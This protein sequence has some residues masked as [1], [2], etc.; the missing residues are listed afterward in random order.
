MTFALLMA[1]ALA[2][3]TAVTTSSAKRAKVSVSAPTCLLSPHFAGDALYTGSV[4][5]QD[6]PLLT[7]THCKI[8]GAHAVHIAPENDTGA[9]FPAVLQ[10]ESPSGSG[11]AVA[12]KG[13][14]GGERY[15]LTISR[16]I[17]ADQ[18]ARAG[19][20]WRI[21]DITTDKQ[22]ASLTITTQHVAPELTAVQVRYKTDAI[23]SAIEPRIV[24]FLNNAM[25]RARE[26]DPDASYKDA[27]VVPAQENSI[28]IRNIAEFSGMRDFP[29]HSRTVADEAEVW[30][31]NPKQI[32]GLEVENADSEKSKCVVKDHENCIED[33]SAIGF[34]MKRESEQP[35]FVD[36]YYSRSRTD[37]GAVIVRRMRIQVQLAA[38]ARRSS[39]PFPL[40]SH[41]YVQCSTNR[42]PWRPTFDIAENGQTLAVNDYV[43]NRDDCSI[44][45]PTHRIDAQI[46]QDL[47]LGV[48]E[49]STC[50]W[51]SVPKYRKA[52]YVVD[53]EPRLREQ[54]EKEHGSGDGTRVNKSPAD[55]FKRDCIE[56]SI[57]PY[58]SLVR[59]APDKTKNEDP[60]SVPATAMK[61]AP[62][63]ETATATKKAPE[64]ET[65]TDKDKHLDRVRALLGPQ[66]LVYEIV[67]ENERPVWHEVALDL[68]AADV[69]IPLEFGKKNTHEAEEFEVRFETLAQAKTD[70]TS[71]PRAG[72]GQRG[73]LCRNPTRCFLARVR[74]KGRFGVAHV[75]GTRGSNSVRVFATIPLDFVAFRF[76]PS[77]R[78]ATSSADSNIAQITT[79]NTGLLLAIEPWNYITNR[80]MFALPFRFLFGGM[81]HRWQ[82]GKFE[83]S[84]FTGGALALPLF[85]GLDANDR[86]SFDLTLSAG[87]ELSLIRS[88]S[89][90][91]D[92]FRG[93]NHFVIAVGLNVFALFS[94]K[95]AAK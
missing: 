81:V 19:S 91:T 9:R 69:R 65:A 7:I 40:V 84:M 62:E 57:P 47:G 29:T 39:V 61:K 85:K 71:S 12:G 17:P 80:N 5:D 3:P 13:K 70:S 94:P 4:S 31:V 51:Y 41:A 6:I 77:G 14:D 48:I 30:V 53:Q 87:W 38:R 86:V 46:N 79:L 11:T 56:Q 64:S 43:I 54:V 15:V 73:D 32:S 60:E 27:H 45:V 24:R 16:A 93:R 28:A 90:A 78:A 82:Q 72:E 33:I 26:A 50:P 76:P 21:Y 67:Q 8:E 95:A 42:L 18:W 37:K 10:V 92:D 66:A 34:Q 25:T 68:T 22:I 52:Q 44:V 59:L 36:L 58:A 20:L 23:P 89:A 83:P 74:S 49:R 1:I 88:A 2:T 55:K 75:R 63:S 35:L